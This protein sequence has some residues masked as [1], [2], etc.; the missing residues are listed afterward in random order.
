MVEQKIR[1]AAA[2]CITEAH[3][4]ATRACWT[5]TAWL[6][7][8]RCAPDKTDFAGMH[9]RQPSLRNV[10]FVTDL[11][12]PWCPHPTWPSE[13]RVCSK[14]PRCLLYSKVC[15]DCVIDKRVRPA[16]VFC[17]TEHES[18][19]RR[20][21]SVLG[22]LLRAC[23][24]ANCNSDSAALVQVIRPGGGAT[25][26]PLWAWTRQ[27]RPCT[28]PAHTSS[29]WRAAQGQMQSLR[30]ISPKPVILGRSA[31]SD[32]FNN[33]RGAGKKQARSYSDQPCNQPWNPVCQGWNPELPWKNIFAVTG[34]SF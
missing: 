22:G 12:N 2:P 7:S 10:V 4:A 11:S 18:T 27:W 3:I 17:N 34:F 9:G 31:Q 6:P 16:H 13:L 26:F 5:G 19:S 28:P 15:D 23:P 32:V 25:C 21:H 14:A 20:V 30:C 8:H 33:Q 1:G 29:T 24:C